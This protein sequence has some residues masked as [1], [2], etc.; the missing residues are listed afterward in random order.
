MVVTFY[1]DGILKDTLRFNESGDINGVTY[2]YNKEKDYI[3]WSNYYNGKREG[4][5]KAITNQGIIVFQHYLN[6]KLHGIEY[7]FSEKGILN[8]KLLWVNDSVLAYEEIWNVDP[9]DTLLNLVDTYEGT[10]KEFQVVE[11]PLILHS[12]YELHNSRFELIGS[13]V[14]K[15]NGILMKEIGQHFYT[16]NMPDTVNISE[17]FKIEIKG[18]FGNLD[19]KEKTFMQVLLYD[20]NRNGEITN[21]KIYKSREKDFDVDITLVPDW[22]G[23][24]L[25]YGKIQ[26]IRNKEELI[27]VLF[28][29]DFYVEGS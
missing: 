17:T 21:H 20:I 4:L 10:E 18:L 28:Y 29:E 26:I 13:L 19:Q 6:D 27:E 15:E 23:Y 5:T 12:F 1:E 16:V 9:N 24:N 2:F 8:S 14:K 7:R 3:R 25:I 22:V 11:N